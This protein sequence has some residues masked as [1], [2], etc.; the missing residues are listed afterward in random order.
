MIKPP[1]ETS[2]EKLQLKIAPISES[3][4][5]ELV[6]L[7]K[8]CFDE[9]WTEE[10]YLNELK[11]SRTACYFACRC[12]DELVG[13]VGAWLILDE[14]HVT[15]VAVHPRMRGRRLG[16]CLVWTLMDRAVNDGCRW[17]TLEVSVKNKP[18]LKIYE[19]FGFKEIGRRRGYYANGEDAIV[20]WVGKLQYPFYRELLDKFRKDWEEKICLSWE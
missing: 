16:K 6:A 9:A 18:A 10:S 5:P 2:A 20:M 11:N 17:A 1:A 12:Q 13:F 19:G 14:A 4:V 3:D 7:E 8:L 15:T